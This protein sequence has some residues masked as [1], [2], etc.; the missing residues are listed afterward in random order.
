MQHIGRDGKLEATATL[1][2][3]CHHLALSAEGLLTFPQSGNEVWLIDPQ[4]LAVRAELPIAAGGKT[5]IGSAQRRIR[6]RR[7][8]SAARWLASISRAARRA[9]QLV[10]DQGISTNLKSAALSPDGKYLCVQAADNAFHRFRMEGTT[11]KFEA[12][13]P[14]IARANAYFQ[15]SPDSKLVAITYPTLN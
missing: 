9:V 10:G 1:P 3:P 5:R 7:C 12:S 2:T 14:S 6:R 4:T 13:K 8:S 15:F 11:L